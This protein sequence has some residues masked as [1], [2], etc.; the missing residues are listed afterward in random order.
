MKVH[1]DAEDVPISMVSAATPE[2]LVAICE[3]KAKIGDKESQRVLSQLT[4]KMVK[5]GKLDMEY[6][7]DIKD[8]MRSPKIINE[9]DSEE[10]KR[11]KENFNNKLKNN[12]CKW[13]NIN[14]Y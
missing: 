4:G 12:R 7:G 10:V 5:S 8:F 14:D 13:S 2:E 6:E 9:F 1:F 3:K 11:Q